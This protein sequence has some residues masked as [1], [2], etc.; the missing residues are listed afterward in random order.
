M[1]CK[2]A[3]NGDFQNRRI[4]PATAGPLMPRG[5]SGSLLG[6]AGVWL[7]CTRNADWVADRAC[8]TS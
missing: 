1:S 2:V 3:G 8:H 6:A 5:S 7:N 4:R